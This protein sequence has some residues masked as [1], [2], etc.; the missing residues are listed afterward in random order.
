MVLRGDDFRIEH[1]NAPMLHMMGRGEEVMGQPFLSIM[2]ELE[3][4]H[5]WQQVERVYREGVSFEQWEVLVPHNR[6]GT[7]QDYY[8]NVAY[9]PLKEDSRIT[10][11]IQVAIDVTEEVVS[12]KKLE[13]SEERYRTLIEETTVA[14]AFYTGPE[15]R[16]R[17]ANA[18]M[19]HYWGKGREAIGKTFREALPELESQPFPGLLEAVYATGESYV[20]TEEKAELRIAGELR[21]FYFNFTYKA[22]RDAEG[23]VYA[24]HHTAMDVTEQVTARRKVEESRQDLHKMILQAPIAIAILR[25]KEYVVEIVNKHALEF[26]GRTYE[27]VINRPLFDA[28]PELRTQGFREFF[29]G[30]YDS[31]VPI[32]LKEHPI[33]FKRAGKTEDFYFNFLYEVLDDANGEVNGLMAIGV[34]VTLQTTTRLKIEEAVEERTKELAKAN[35]ELQRSNANLEEFAHAAS[36]D[37]KEPVRK[38]HFFTT[39]LKAGLKTRLEETEIRSFNRIE[40]AT[41]RMGALIDDLLLYSHVSQRPHETEAVNLNVKIQRVIEDLELDIEEKKA[42]ITIGTLPVVQGYTRQLQQLFQNLISNALKYSK[43]DVPPH[44][45]ISAAEAEENG[46]KY[47]VILVK[48]NGIGFDPQYA[49]K[50]FQMFARLHSKTEYSGTGVGLSIV[51]KVVENHSGFIRVESVVGAGSVFKI[52]LPV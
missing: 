35:A 16:I 26:W 40:A 39:Q 10:G 36:H 38:I 8:Y 5:A 20:G 46:R 47:N 1:I 50:I 7:M 34:D 12:R 13:E 29:D 14:T 9:R 41:E 23:R 52:Y 37:L 3:G 45:E 6:T 24:V 31:G 19:L 44:I 25:T 22:L 21:P 43:A 49:E 32:H 28:L 11:M 2:P 15:V 51:K 42:V 4:Q 33:T 17:Y 18:T 48:D 27:E 30:I